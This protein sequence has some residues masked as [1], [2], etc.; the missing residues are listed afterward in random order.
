MNSCRA[1]RVIQS[2]IDS[3][4]TEL[5][6]I[7]LQEPRLNVNHEFNREVSENVII[8]ANFLSALI[9]CDEISKIIRNCA[10][11]AKIYIINRATSELFSEQISVE[12]DD[13]KCDNKKVNI[14]Q[15]HF[16][17]KKGLVSISVDKSHTLSF[18]GKKDEEVF[19]SS[20]KPIDIINIGVSFTD[21]LDSEIQSVSFN[22]NIS[23]LVKGN[24]IKFAIEFYVTSSNVRFLP[25][26]VFLNL[27]KKN[28]NSMVSFI[29]SVKGENRLRCEFDTDVAGN[30][31]FYF[32]SG[33]LVIGHSSALLLKWNMG[34]FK[35]IFSK[36]ST[37]FNKDHVV[38]PEL[39][40]F[41]KILYKQ[42][43]AV[44]SLLFTCII[45]G[46]VVTVFPLWCCTSFEVELKFSFWRMLFFTSLAGLFYIYYCYWKYMNMFEALQYSAPVAIVMLLSLNYILDIN[47][48]V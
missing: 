16:N 28:S 4:V 37:I 22:S 29:A 44:I 6:S 35:I 27:F 10:K 47:T 41:P 5:S 2:D 8:V 30:Q 17:Y 7:V 19:F 42:P 45:L 21:S 11:I 39:H 13:V 43:F 38:L 3:L 23:D 1:P 12:L 31:S 33:E 20:T 48:N 26:Q 32:L 24:L 9:D 25:S 18:I 15:A 40:N 14:N 36:P 34:E 46:I